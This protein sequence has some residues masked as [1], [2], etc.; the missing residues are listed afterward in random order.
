MDEQLKRAIQNSIIHWYKDIVFPLLG[1]L[2]IEKSSNGE[3]CWKETNIKVKCYSR[4]CVLCKVLKDDCDKCPLTEDGKC[5]ND[6]PSPWNRFQ[7]KP[8]LKNA[9]NM[10][11]VLENLL[12]EKK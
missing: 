4:H 1:G 3:L 9:K 5:C 6:D 8:T 7:Y 11:R 12:E 2:K 10:I